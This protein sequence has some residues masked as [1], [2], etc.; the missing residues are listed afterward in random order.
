MTS[1]L[2]QFYNA[3]KHSRE[4]E[5]PK[6]SD[7]PELKALFGPA[8]QRMAGI[9]KYFVWPDRNAVLPPFFARGD[10]L[11]LAYKASKAL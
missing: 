10:L 4:W 9:F 11:V 8:D 3:L 7:E 5:H 2:Y 1:F 6:V